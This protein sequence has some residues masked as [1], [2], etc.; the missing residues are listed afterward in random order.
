MNASES[1][2]SRSSQVLLAV[3]PII[4]WTVFWMFI[5][6]WIPSGGLLSRPW[7]TLLIFALLT[8]AVFGFALAS[9]SLAALTLPLGGFTV[10]LAM[11]SFMSLLFVPVSLSTFIAL[12]FFIGVGLMFFHNIRKESDGMLHFR[13]SKLIRRTIPLF[14]SM[15][16]AV[17]S[18]VYYAELNRN[19]SNKTDTIT[20]L[21]IGV[22]NLAN[23]LLP[24]FLP[25]YVP[26]DTLDAFLLRQALA[27]SE[28]I[29]KNAETDLMEELPIEMRR[30]LEEGGDLSALLEEQLHGD[31]AEQISQARTQFLE[32]FG[33]T[34]TGNE[35]MTLILQRIIDAKAHEWIDD[36]A[37]LIPPFFA[38]GLF[39]FLQ[40]FHWIYREAAALWS[41]FLLTVFQA[42]GVLTIKKR[43]AEQEVVGVGRG[44]EKE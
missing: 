1:K 31:A 2:K 22:G 41:L 35:P 24:A 9:T 38:V 29:M 19:P 21:S 42:L 44:F 12:I 3:L 30:A 37:F 6:L 11:A 17:V 39:L 27:Q 10:S 4:A 14:L 13:L 18:V 32:P 8:I 26:G 28:R 34:A 20:N 40:F 23:Q 16:L 33:I 43:P 7:P 15:A 5:R 36:Y 25:G